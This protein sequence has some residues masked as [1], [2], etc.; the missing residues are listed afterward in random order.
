[1][2]LR[3]VDGTVIGNVSSTN[4]ALTD[5]GNRNLGHIVCEN[6][7]Q[8]SSREDC[9]ST[10]VQ[11]RFPETPPASGGTLIYPDDADTLCW[12]VSRPD[13]LPDDPTTSNDDHGMEC[14]ASAGSNALGGS[15]SA[16]F[17]KSTFDENHY[18]SS[19]EAAASDARLVA[20][21][22]FRQCWTW[23]YTTG[24][25]RI[26]PDDSVVLPS[27]PLALREPCP[28]LDSS[29]TTDPPERQYKGR[30]GWTCHLSATRRLPCADLTPEGI[31]ANSVKGDVLLS[32][33]PDQTEF[34]V[35]FSDPLKDALA[36]NDMAHPDARRAVKT[37]VAEY[38]VQ[39]SGISLEICEHAGSSELSKADLERAGND[40]DLACVHRSFTTGFN[41]D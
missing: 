24:E 19:P 18:Y 16:F 31:E 23:D 22:L 20:T 40:R 9:L 30:M 35:F 26:R 25:W 28:A 2:I 11:L 1:M 3:E 13:S 6:P 32:Y 17:H 10:D 36:T 33:F 7:V 14:W 38:G 12:H 8:A 21:N 4:Q 37:L 39:L 5:L 15:I 27:A 34:D 29:G 41:Q